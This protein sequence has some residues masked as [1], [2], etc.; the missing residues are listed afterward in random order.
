MIDADPRHP[1]RTAKQLS[2]ATHRFASYVD[3][4][5]TT[6][7]VRDDINTYLPYLLESNVWI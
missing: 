3:F 4:S 1:I 6:F 5:E 7:L 2:N